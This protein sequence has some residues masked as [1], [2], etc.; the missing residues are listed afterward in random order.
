MKIPSRAGMR[1]RSGFRVP[2]MFLVL[3]FDYFSWIIYQHH[4]KRWTFGGQQQHLNR[5]HDILIKKVSYQFTRPCHS[6][7]TCHFGTFSDFL[8]NVEGVDGRV[9]LGSRHA[10]LSEAFDVQV[11]VSVHAAC[12][13]DYDADLMCFDN[14]E[15]LKMILLPLL[16]LSS[17]PPLPLLCTPAAPT[18]F[19][20]L[21]KCRYWPVNSRRGRKE[22]EESHIFPHRNLSRVWRKEERD[23]PAAI[24]QD[25][26]LNQSPPVRGGRLTNVE[27]GG[28]FFH[29]IITKTYSELFQRK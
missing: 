3:Q 2:D 21:L 22:D 20:F 19:W 13:Q 6:I 10:V 7:Y 17:S 16:L 11:L 23:H 18:D 12:Q 24:I 4:Q 8:S 9:R 28:T 5:G 15:V 29:H 25:G 26:W 1:R 27:E 14:T